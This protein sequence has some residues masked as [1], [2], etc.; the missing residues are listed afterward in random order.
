MLARK[1]LAALEALL[2]VFVSLVIVVIALP[3]GIVVGGV[4]ALLR[5]IHVGFVADITDR[6]MNAMISAIKL[7]T[8]RIR[9]IARGLERCSTAN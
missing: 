1:I 9:N 6:F 2:W 4:G 7:I 8:V 5:K 3:V